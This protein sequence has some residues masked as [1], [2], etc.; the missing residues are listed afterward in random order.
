[1]TDNPSLRKE[2]D[3]NGTEPSR[4]DGADLRAHENGRTGGHGVGPPVTVALT[5]DDWGFVRWCILTVSKGFAAEQRGQV[6]ASSLLERFESA[7]DRPRTKIIT[8]IQ[9][10]GGEHVDIEVPDG[11]PP[12]PERRA[13]APNLLVVMRR[14]QTAAHDLTIKIMLL[15]RE[16]PSSAFE[17]CTCG[18]TKQDHG[19]GPDPGCTWWSTCRC[20]GYA[21]GES[22]RDA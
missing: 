6:A 8:A 10:P 15:G 2:G 21:R 5:A 22:I 19:E 12:A 16:L 13:P 4:D 18:H 14:L 1:M 9:Q 7:L 3:A 17:F 11:C 20:R